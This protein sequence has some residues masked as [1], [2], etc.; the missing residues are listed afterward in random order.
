VK[1]P[2]DVL[3]RTLASFS[4]RLDERENFILPERRYSHFGEVGY[5]CEQF[6]V[7]GV[8]ITQG[9]AGTPGGDNSPSPGQPLLI[10][11]QVDVMIIREVPNLDEID[12][13]PDSDELIASATEVGSDVQALT[14]TFYGAFGKESDEIVDQCDNVYMGGVTWVG[15]EGDLIATILTFYVQL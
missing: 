12:Q 2:G 15:P 7:N 5:D 3:N 9:A 11:L 8:N 10:Y 14:D 4:C 6:V 1:N 13:P